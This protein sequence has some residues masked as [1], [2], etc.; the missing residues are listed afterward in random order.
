MI[1]GGPEAGTPGQPSDEEAWRSV[2]LG[3]EPSLNRI[4]RVWRHVPSDPR[5]KLCWSP[6]GGLGSVIS[7]LT[8]HRASTSNPTMCGPCTKAL[9]GRPGGAEIPLSV[10]FADVRGSTGV[11][12]AMTPT[13]YRNLLQRFYGLASEAITTHDG[14]VDK[15]LGDGVMALFIPAFA[16]EG[17]AGRA[18]AAAEALRRRLAEMPEPRLPVG[19]GVHTGTAFAGAIGS[20]HEIDFSALGD[21]VNVAARLGSEAPAGTILISADT[22]AADGRE[23]P[24]TAHRSLSLKGRTEPI[25]VVEI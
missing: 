13:A 6:F 2:L 10:L 25:E 5:C 15:Y 14:F 8:G 23:L 1:G 4:R 17:H 3:T 7:V 16:G 11:A 20:G 22:A 9:R 12:E 19:V 21:A 18:V 24:S